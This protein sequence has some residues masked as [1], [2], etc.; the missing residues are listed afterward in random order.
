MEKILIR[1]LKNG[2]ML[3]VIPKKG[4]VRAEAMLAVRYGS[5]FTDFNINGK[6]F[7]TPMGIA[8]FLEHKLFDDK[9]GN[10]MDKFSDYGAEVNAFTNFYTTAYYFTATNNFYDCLKLLCYMLSSLFLT[11]EGINKEKAIIEQ[12]INMYKDDYNWQC[13]F[14]LLCGMY[15]SNP[16][17]NNIAGTVN[18]VYSITKQQLQLCYDTFYTGDNMALIVAGDV[19]IDEI[20][21][22]A[23]QM[24]ISYGKIVHV[25]IG[26][27]QTPINEAYIE[28]KMNVNKP[29]FS[30]GFKEMDYNTPLS[31]KTAASIII[32]DMLSGLGSDLYTKMYNDN[33]IGD[34][35]YFEHLNGFGYGGDIFSGTSHTPYRVAESII[36]QINYYK[37]NGIDKNVIDRIIKK[38]KGKIYQ[39]YNS[40]SYICNTIAD[41]FAKKQQPLENFYM[42]D[43]ITYSDVEKRLMKHFKEENMVI[44]VIN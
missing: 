17:R 30:I 15:K 43:K 11:N 13:Y 36:N 32:M 40:L 16:V 42:Y 44:S 31:I 5:T 12:E 34:D 18:S 1:K 35:F 24:D 21:K 9:M 6:K 23:I 20:E 41:N 28:Q 14:N 7:T 3:Y 27:N 29:V 4:Y 2:M 38:N 26:D 22:I 10:L 8:H 19:D 25:E 37:E 33:L 39:A